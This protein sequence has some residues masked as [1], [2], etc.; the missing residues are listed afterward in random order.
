MSEIR[1][2]WPDRESETRNSDMQ[3]LKWQHYSGRN[4]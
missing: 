2:N 1:Q 3:P 4:P